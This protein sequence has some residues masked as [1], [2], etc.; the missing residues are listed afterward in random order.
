MFI[1]TLTT[2]YIIFSIYFYCQVNV[3]Y[4]LPIY[5]VTKSKTIL[6]QKNTNYTLCVARAHSKQDRIR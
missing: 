4:M 6:I 3:V 1:M 2:Y 5:I